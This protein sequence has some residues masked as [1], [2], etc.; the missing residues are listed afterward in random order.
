MPF[1]AAGFQCA[2]MAEHSVPELCCRPK[3]LL[4][5]AA[6]IGSRP[7]SHGVEDASTSGGGDVAESLDRLRGAYD[8]AVCALEGDESAGDSQSVM[9]TNSQWG[10][11]Q[12]QFGALSREVTRLHRD[13]TA[14]WK[15]VDSLRHST[16]QIES[17]QTE[18]SRQWSMAQA[19]VA[20]ESMALSVQMTEDHGKLKKALEM[21]NNSIAKIIADAAGLQASLQKEEARSRDSL[22]VLSDE[23]REEAQQRRLLAGE[24]RQALA[25]LS[26]WSEDEKHRE[27]LA[28]RRLGELSAAIDTLRDLHTSDGDKRDACH[29]E[30]HQ[31]LMASMELHAKTDNHMKDVH[32]AV[33]DVTEMY[34]SLECSMADQAAAALVAREADHEARQQMNTRSL[35]HMSLQEVELRKDL[36]ALRDEMQ[37]EAERRAELSSELRIEANQHV[38]DVREVVNDVAKLRLSVQQDAQQ[39]AVQDEEVLRAVEW[40]R[41]AEAK[42]QQSMSAVSSY[43]QDR[44]VLAANQRELE[45]T[46]RRELNHVVVQWEAGEAGLRSMISEKEVRINELSRDVQHLL[47]FENAIREQSKQ[48]GNA[49]IRVPSP[50]ECLATS[51]LSPTTTT[52]G[53]TSPMS[54]LPPNTPGA[55]PSPGVF[56]AKPTEAS[57]TAG[58]VFPKTPGAL[59]GIPQRMQSLG[60]QPL[61]APPRVEGANLAGMPGQFPNSVLLQRPPSSV[62]RS[63]STGQIGRAAPVGQV[64]AGRRS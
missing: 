44:P 50:R 16:M 45:E 12:G 17:R 3:S 28:A 48:V 57:Q 54:S 10:L 29:M 58:K 26:R 42:L 32:Q 9:T 7:T 4:S 23:L 56:A 18:S 59:L 20:K 37:E 27:A 1:V 6:S 53:M 11:V 63:S 24:L 41:E 61:K 62:Q 60:S 31:S 40:S 35:E 64:A 52:I 46:F 51:T 21:Q 36:V 14:I 34:R 49:L 55:S 22:Q 8:R 19:E 13:L 43:W 38:T 25:D 15:E 33:G 5:S 47:E 30:L 2:A 39:R